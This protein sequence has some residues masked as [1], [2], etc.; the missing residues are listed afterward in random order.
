MPLL[1]GALL[2]TVASAYAPQQATPAMPTMLPFISTSNRFE[3][4][5]N[6]LL[7]PQFGDSLVAP[8]PASSAIFP[9]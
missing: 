7:S 6:T 5:G 9:M 3:V 8:S 1:A 4:R 2:A